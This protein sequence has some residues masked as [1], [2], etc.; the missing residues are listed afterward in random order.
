MY[1]KLMVNLK[2]NP[3]AGMPTTNRQ[4]VLLV[5]R[6]PVTLNAVTAFSSISTAACGVLPQASDAA[7]QA[8]CSSS[9]YMTAV[10][11]RKKD[12]PSAA[13]ASSAPG[14]ALAIYPNPA[15]TSV[16]LACTITEPGPVRVFMS[17]ALGREGREVLQE[18]RPAAGLFEVIVPLAGLAPGI[19]YCTL[20]TTVDRTV[21][22]LVVVP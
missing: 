1:V 5:A 14:Q 16:R 17:D 6:Y 19:Y 11:L 13:T 9:K 21:R 8:T 3:V 18:T 2:P 7:V 15:Q 4:N 10:T 20:Q 12:E 22:K